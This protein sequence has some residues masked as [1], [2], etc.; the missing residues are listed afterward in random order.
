MVTEK[1]GEIDFEFDGC[2]DAME[3]V[4]LD[5]EMAEMYTAANLTAAF[6]SE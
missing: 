3:T 6:C 1:I 5:G 2:L 4:R